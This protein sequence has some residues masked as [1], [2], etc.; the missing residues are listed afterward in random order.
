MIRY[1]LQCE[2][3]HRFEGWFQ[4]SD[5]FDAQASQGHV[6]CPECGS[7]TVEKSLMT[8]GVPKKSAETTIG[9]REFFNQ[10]RAF[11]SKV[12]A[13]TDDVGKA[14]PEQARQMHDGDIEHRPIRGNATPEEVK[15]LKDDGIAVAPIPPEPP[16]EN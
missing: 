16:K 12:I 15:E 5:A 7:V 9:P 4:S 3:A 11:R 13:E 10:V 6:S 14:F 2:K 8:P 1:T